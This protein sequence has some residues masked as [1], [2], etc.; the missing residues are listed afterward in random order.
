MDV[1]KWW[2]EN[3]N[4]Y[5]LLYEAAKGLLHTPA[6]SVPSERIFS[7]AGYIARARRSKILPVNLNRHLFIKKNLK[8]VPTDV[9]K[10]TEDIATSALQENVEIPEIF[11]GTD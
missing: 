7:E 3:K 6:T 8:Y 1:L 10:F 5:P 9:D 4:R 11:P 2:K